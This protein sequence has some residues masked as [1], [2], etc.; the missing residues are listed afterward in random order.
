MEHVFEATAGNRSKVHATV[1]KYPDECPICHV[2]VSPAR[3]EAQFLEVGEKKLLEVIFRCTN[4]KCQHCFIAMYDVKSFD[5]KNNNNVSFYKFTFSV[6]RPK[7]P[8]PQHFS[9]QI[10]KVSPSFTKIYNQAI[11][12]ESQGLTEINGIG[13]RKSIEFLVKDFAIHLSP[14]KEEEIKKA[15]L[16]GTIKTYIKDE[17]VKSMA[18]LATWL[19]NDETHY[20]RKWENKDIED[21]KRLIRLTVNAIENALLME[22]YEK[23]MNPDGTS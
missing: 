6:A 23:E 7:I 2:M 13:L 14:D 5:G 22:E 15:K 20:V 11:A 3:I 10:T 21:L 12:A 4:H 8:L 9:E 19:G 1:D 18:T 16:G 17:A